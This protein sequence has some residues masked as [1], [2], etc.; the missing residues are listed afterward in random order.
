MSIMETNGGSVVAMVGKD[1]VA[2]ASDLRLGN[3]AQGLAANFQKVFS[4]TD[5]IYLGLPGLATDV[6]TLYERFRFRTNM[7]TIKEERE[8]SPET[9]AHLVSS[10]LYEHRFGPYFIEPVIAGISAAPT[11]SPSAVS[12]GTLAPPP[13]KKWQPFIAAT[14]V[15][16]CI[17][18]AK[19][20]VVAGTASSTL[21]GVAE[22]LWEPDLEP[23]DLFE[24]I[25]QTMLNALDRDAYSGWGVVVHVITPDKV[26]TR[27]LKARMD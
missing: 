25:S 6:T 9:F 2:I 27:T 14:D 23:E 24:T 1:C 16:G 4:I 10:T 17:N 7:Y 21:F 22:G 13:G 15:I 18:F 11:A 5:R 26:I 12:S 19:D 20:F 3:Q 8:I